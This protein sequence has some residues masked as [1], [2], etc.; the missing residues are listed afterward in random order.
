M[1]QIRPDRQM[2]MFSATWPK[3]VRSLARQHMVND[4][5]DSN[6]FQ[7]AIGSMNKL[8]ASEDVK[9]IIKMSHTA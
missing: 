7:V 1:S 5:N 4:E 3:E 9:Q 6:V 8:R 2:C